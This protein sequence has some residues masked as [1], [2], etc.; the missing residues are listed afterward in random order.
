MAHHVHNGNQVQKH[1]ISKEN[2]EVT[3]GPFS[4][5]RETLHTDQEL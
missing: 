2:V 5:L 3:F 1:I 4:L